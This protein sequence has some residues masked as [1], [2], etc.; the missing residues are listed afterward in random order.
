MDGEVSITVTDEREEF[1]GSAPP[2]S[3]ESNARPLLLGTGIHRMQMLMD[4]L[5]FE[6]SGKIVHMRKRLHSSS[7]SVHK[8]APKVL[9][10]A[11]V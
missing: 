11:Q 4:E 10:A 7:Q 6:E 9:H 5:S 1:D 8:N 3:T 2:D